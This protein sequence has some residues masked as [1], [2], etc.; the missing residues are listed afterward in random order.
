MGYKKNINCSCYHD[1][2][3]FPERP[4]LSGEQ[5]LITDPSKQMAIR[6]N[7]LSLLPSNTL[8]ERIKGIAKVLGFLNAVSSGDISPEAEAQASRKMQPIIK[9]L[10]KLSLSTPDTIEEKSEV[11]EKTK[12]FFE[13]LPPENLLPLPSDTQERNAAILR[14]SEVPRSSSSGMSSSNMEEESS[15]KEMLLLLVGL[16]QLPLLPQDMGEL[17]GELERSIKNFLSTISSEDLPVEGEMR[18]T[19]MRLSKLLISSLD[20]Q[21]RQKKH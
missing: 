5:N 9:E 3:W 10:Y 14:F 11:L 4:N 1:Y 20:T 17:R 21:E 18:E 6:L 15:S 19:L 8:E 7:E 2:F 16:N 13:E 12:N